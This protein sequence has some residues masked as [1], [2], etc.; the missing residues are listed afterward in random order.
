MLNPIRILPALAMFVSLP[1]LAQQLV[2]V[3][4]PA[5]PGKKKDK[6]CLTPGGIGNKN[7]R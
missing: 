4:P 6:N 2:P 3:V 7:S 1:S 5:G